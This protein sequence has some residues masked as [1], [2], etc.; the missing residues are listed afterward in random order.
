MTG[1]FGGLEQTILEL[2]DAE[3]ADIIAE[4]GP[5]AYTITGASPVAGTFNLRRM[6]SKGGLTT[7]FNMV[8]TAAAVAPAN[9]FC[10]LV[11]LDGSLIAVT[12]DRSADAALLGAG[13]LWSPPW[14][15]PV[16]LPPGDMYGC[17]MS[18]ATT[19]T[20]PQFRIY[21]Q[22]AIACVNLGCTPAKGNLRAASGGVGLNALPAFPLVIPNLQAVSFNPF[23]AC[24]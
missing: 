13:V 22:V 11:G 16:N 4:T 9:V 20:P 24:T 1:F 6:T 3:P 14:I 21:A 15:N 12:A 23:M 18:G 10:A 7:N 17:F 19:T 8:V 5:F 2:A